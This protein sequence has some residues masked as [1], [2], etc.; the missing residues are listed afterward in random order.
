MAS[1]NLNKNLSQQICYPHHLSG[2][3]LQRSSVLTPVHA[4]KLLGL[5][6]KQTYCALNIT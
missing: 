1:Q 4:S 6:L 3:V 2:T 5:N